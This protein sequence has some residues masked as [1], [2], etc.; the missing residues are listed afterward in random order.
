MKETT[1]TALFIAT[2]LAM[3]G[4]NTMPDNRH[5]IEI[6]FSPFNGPT[7]REA[8]I[9]A[10]STYDADR[11]ARGIA[12]L[13]QAD[14]GG[15]DPY[16]KLYR[17]TIKIDPDAT[18]RTAA[19]KAL[20]MHG[21]VQDALLFIEVLKDEQASVR[22]E[23]ARALQ[24]IHNPVV[25][26]PL[27]EVLKNDEDEN[28]RIA[29]A[30]ALGQYAQPGVFDSLVAALDDDSYGVVRISQ[31]SLSTLTGQALG[32]DPQRWF[33]WS[34][35]N[36][37]NLFVGRKQYV[38]HDY[39]VPPTWSSRMIFWKRNDYTEDSARLPKGIE[40]PSEPTRIQ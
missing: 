31:Q 25:T 4:C 17:E 16:V 18:V 39:Q 3:T 15:E 29:A 8:A 34:E 20:G 2:A 5:P 1:I 11:R 38:W 40:P 35:K 22:W 19:V 21:D 13:A 12:T 23:A 27:S 6:L 37:G 24:K 36:Q 9:D 10:V 7:P 26:R 32:D 14:F 33:S 30:Y 28:V